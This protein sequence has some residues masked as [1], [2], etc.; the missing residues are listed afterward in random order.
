MPCEGTGGVRPLRRRRRRPRSRA[1]R[2]ERRADRR[3]CARRGAARARA[4]AGVRE[5]RGT[6]AGA[7]KARPDGEASADH[8]SARRDV[9]VREDLVR[10]AHG[11]AGHA[12]LREARLDVH[13]VVAR[14]PGGDQRVGGGAMREPRRRRREARIL[15][16]VG[17][18]DRRAQADERLVASA[19][20]RDPT[21]VARGV[22]VG[23][24]HGER[25]G[26]HAPSH[27]A[28]ALVADEGVLLHAHG[29]LVEA[30]V[31]HL[32]AAAPPRLEHRHQRRAR[33]EDGRP[34]LGQRSR[35]E[36]RRAVGKAG[37]ELHAREGLG[38]A[39][40]GVLGGER[41]RLAE[42]RD[43]QE[44]QPRVALARARRARGPRP[45]AA[46]PQILHEGVGASRARR[47]SHGSAARSSA[48]GEDRQLAAVLRLEVERVLAVDGRA[49][50][51]GAASPRAARP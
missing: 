12:G 33:S 48:L 18:L 15:R 20:E 8:A 3:R 47:A 35:D 11:G 2:V 23:G 13:E 50:A 41:P 28:V 22:D 38:D 30:D 17:R 5:N 37:G 40:V 31:H 43:A 51:G 44:H 16:R 25:L 42:R 4:P 39:V 45:R 34:A 26:A 36:H 27:R 46:R 7:E 10:G 9:L 21:A 14:D 29:G 19:G 24:D 49:R 6:G 32:A 1:D